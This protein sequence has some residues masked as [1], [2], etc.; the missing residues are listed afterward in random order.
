MVNEF[1]DKTEFYKIWKVEALIRVLAKLY[2]NSYHL[3][4]F[5]CCREV[6]D[7]FRHTGCVGGTYDEA[8]AQF[9]AKE[10]EQKQQTEEERSIELKKVFSK[11][12]QLENLISKAPMQNVEE[13]KLK[14]E[15]DRDDESG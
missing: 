2:P 5:A 12:Y 14:P 4:F 10:Q 15:K 1:D 3:A 11:I 7:P 9:K 6:Y 13:Q 8:V